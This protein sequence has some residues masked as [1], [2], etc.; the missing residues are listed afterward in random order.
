MRKSSAQ[1][2][3]ELQVQLADEKLWNERIAADN[4][5]FRARIEQ[6]EDKKKLQEKHIRE[7]SLVIRQYQVA[8]KVLEDCLP[9]LNTKDKI[10]FE[11]ARK[12]P[13]V[14]ASFSIESDIPADIQQQIDAFLKAEKKIQAIKLYRDTTKQSLLDSKKTV[15]KRIH[16]LGLD[17]PM[18]P[19]RSPF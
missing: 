16:E 19:F 6:L 17:G 11:T 14:L 9:V 2:I 10:L 7:K 8:L 12:H 15:E 5:D 1:I 3:K 4:A 13:E 18:G